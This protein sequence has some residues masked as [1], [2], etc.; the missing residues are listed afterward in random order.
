MYYLKYFFVMSIVGFII[1]SFVYSNLGGSGILYGPWTIIY[2]LGSIVILLID[3]FVRKKTENKFL[4]VI[5]LFLFST[6]ILTILEFIGGFLIEKVFGI[7]FW[8]Y[9]SFKFHIGKYICIE[10]ALLWGIA[11]ISFIYLIKPIIEYVIKFIPKIL[12]YILILLMVID[13]ICVFIFK[14]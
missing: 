11:S 13:F 7:V 14:A 6:F 5:L 3:K 8:D 4:R 12:V 2:G 10:M 1:E 9:S